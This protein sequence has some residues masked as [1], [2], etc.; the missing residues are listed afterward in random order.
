M[1]LVNLFKIL[2]LELFYSTRISNELGAGHPERAKHAMRVTLKLSVLLGFCFVLMLLFG[3][4][5]WIQFFS[6]SPII[7][8]EFASIT[9][10]LAI[11]ILLDSVQ[12]VLSGLNFSSL[13]NLSFF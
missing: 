13:F 5:I 7:K 11:S 12:G 9:P 3:H 10:L 2:K 6:S 4:D 8:K 1:F